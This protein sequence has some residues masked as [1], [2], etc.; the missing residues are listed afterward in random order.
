MSVSP[1][2]SKPTSPP[3]TT[4]R[5]NTSRLTFWLL[6]A[7]LILLAINMRAPIVALGSIAPVISEALSLSAMQIGWL[8]ALPML[9]FALGSL[10]SP[11]LG[12]RYGLE[13]ILIAM[14][15]LL[16]LGIILRV[17]WVSWLGFLTGTAVLT[18]AIGFANTLA[19]PIIKAHA[20]Q[21][22]SL[23]TGVLS[24]TMTL[25]AG[26]SAGSVLPLS[27][28]VG[29]QWALGA[30]AGFGIAALVVWWVLKRHLGTAA[31]RPT[32]TAQKAARSMWRIPLAWQIAIFMG[33]QSLLFYTVASFLPS[34]WLSKGLSAT[35][36]A[37]MGS[38]F[39]FMGPIAIVSLTWLMSRYSMLRTLSVGAAVLN[40]VGVA[41]MLSPSVTLAWLWSMLMGL[42]CSLIFTLSMMLFS[43]RTHTPEESSTLSGMV[44]SVGYLL[45]FF[46]PLG[47]GW[48]HEQTGSWQLALWLMLVLMIINV[49]L[50]WQ[51]SRP[52]MIDGT[53]SDE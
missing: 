22:I 34:I 20:P 15:G 26:V 47:S 44:Q 46:G 41:G 7:A 13:N 6:I 8:G 38:L 48:L 3:A 24:L 18:L 21:H 39:Q 40:V 50:A 11:A 35:Q 36:A 29:W 31:K 25:S 23:M 16:T 27:E 4:A 14:I 45:A 1:A 53:A 5:S 19:A 28:R 9:A 52:M 10:I 17:V 49:L 12:R 51:V 2:T 32:R 42:G 43:I 30:W 37:S 33:I